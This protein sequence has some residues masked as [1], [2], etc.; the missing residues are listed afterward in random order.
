MQQKQVSESQNGNNI[1]GKHHVLQDLPKLH[2][3]LNG[4]QQVNERHFEEKGK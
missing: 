4:Q 1:D 2:L 3:F